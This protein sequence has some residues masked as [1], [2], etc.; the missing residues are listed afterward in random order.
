MCKI[1]YYIA[2]FLVAMMIITAPFMA[3]WIHLGLTGKL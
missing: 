2:E 1:L 3:S